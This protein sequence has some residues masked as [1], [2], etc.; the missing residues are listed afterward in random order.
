MP[1]PGQSLEDDDE[2]DGIEGD[3]DDDDDLHRLSIHEG[4]ISTSNGTI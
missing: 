2:D 3:H 4:K 1:K